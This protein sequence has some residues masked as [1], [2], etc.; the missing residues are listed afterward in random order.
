MLKRMGLSP[1]RTAMGGQLR[2]GQSGNGVE[3]GLVLS[4]DPT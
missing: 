3:L 2:H 1:W 4:T